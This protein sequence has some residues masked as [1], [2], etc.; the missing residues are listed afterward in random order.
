VKKAF[1]YSP[2]RRAIMAKGE[3]INHTEVYDFWGWVCH[4]CGEDISPLAKKD[5]WMRVTL[6]HVIPLSRGGTHTWDNVKPAHW[7]CNMTKGNGI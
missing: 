3:Q 4:L 5:D 2:K 6:D 7:Q 1:Y